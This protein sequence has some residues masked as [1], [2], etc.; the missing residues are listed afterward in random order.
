MA[1]VQAVVFVAAVLLAYKMLADP[2]GLEETMIE[3]KR[4]AKGEFHETKY[5]FVK[6]PTTLFGSLPVG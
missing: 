2:K 4:Y 6:I 3:N 1:G 5:R